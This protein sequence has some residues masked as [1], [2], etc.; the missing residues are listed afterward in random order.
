MSKL[1][2]KTLIPL[3]LGLVFFFI[4][5][6]AAFVLRALRRDPMHRKFDAALPTYRIRTNPTSRESL[7]R[8]Y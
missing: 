5:S 6:P 4:V 2:R 7:E 1:L 8:P 3:V